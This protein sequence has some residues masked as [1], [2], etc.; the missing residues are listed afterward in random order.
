M[1]IAIIG[2]GDIGFHLAK[3]LSMEQH[4]ITVIESDPNRVRKAKEQ[5]DAF[6]VNGSGCS[7]QILQK[8]Q[9]SNVDIFAAL[10]NNDEVNIL[11]CFFAKKIG[12]GTT[13]AR[14]RNPE[15]TREDLLEHK[16]LGID[17]VIHPEKLTASVI[18]QL[19]RQSA[20]TDIVSFENG[21]IQLAGIRLDE[22][23]PVLDIPLK[24]MGARFGNPDHRIVAIKRRHF[25]I[26]PRG[27]DILVEGDQIFVIC[28]KEYL[29]E[30]IKFY[31][32][33]ESKVENIMIVGG[34]LIGRFIAK[35]LEN[36]ISIKII[37]SNKAK[38][39]DL[40]DILN[41]TL[42]INGDGSNIDLLT[43]EALD[44]M[45]EF[46]AVTGD[47]EANI[48]TSLVAKHLK[49]PRTITLLRKMEYLPLT[50]AIGIDSIISKQQ[51]TVN[52]VQKFIR[53]TQIASY[54]EIPNV[55]VEFIEF[56]ATER[57]KII[58]KP[59][60]KIRFPQKAIVGAVFRK[61]GDVEIPKGNTTI[62]AGDRV[63][64]VAMV[65]AIKE[66]EKLF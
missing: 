50:P 18:A 65:D 12:V 36:E 41:H 46:I 44:E 27:D 31:G 56:I 25:T 43:F 66:I 1:N 48:I 11:A 35:E 61:N 38:A 9:I 64:V 13:I 59:L 54:A 57:S 7:Y 8:A 49:V 16:D 39:N 24:D 30:A 33:L 15:Y 28:S 37:E 4:N 58:G 34:G 17:F 3:R 53:S 32:K 45:D 29:S 26:V 42:V 62:E 60:M 20:A 5:L 51:I 21:K 14:V 22:D 23:C 2:A 6:V 52:A 19:V 47:D 40:A 10:T 63:I 55:D